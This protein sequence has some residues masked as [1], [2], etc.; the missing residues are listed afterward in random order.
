[1]TGRHCTLHLPWPPS[2][3][4][5]WRPTGSK[6]VLTREARQFRAN[7]LACILEQGSPRLGAAR[8][9]VRV[10]VNAP[11][12]RKRDLDNFGGKA[13]LDA[14]A[15]AQVFDNDEQIDELHVVRGA[16]TKPGQVLVHV[17]IIPAPQG[18]HEAAGIP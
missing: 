9:R 13:V 7:A 10:T 12:H 4:K 18:A 5:Y 3:N 1:M 8:L 2:T 11:D 15:F 6:L 17:E 16:V 14:L